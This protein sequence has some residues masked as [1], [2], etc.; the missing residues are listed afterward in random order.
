MLGIK[1]LESTLGITTDQV[2]ARVAH[3]RDHF[4]Q[5]VEQGQRGKLLVTDRGLAILHRIIELE[6][7]GHSLQTATKVI[8][9]DLEDG[10]SKRKI[11][12]PKESQADPI[13]VQT[14]QDTVAL[15]RAQLDTK[16]LEIERLHDLLHR[17]LPY[18]SQARTRWQHLKAVFLGR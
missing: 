16:D 15:L 14:L 2:R 11:G 5:V 9:T 6:T 8:R 4:D 18:H 3:L 13:L 1:E 10:V 7:Q 12:I 17:Q